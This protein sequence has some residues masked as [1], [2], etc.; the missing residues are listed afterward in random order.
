MGLS[1]FIARLPLKGDGEC[2]KDAE[3]LEAS[4]SVI[5]SR[6]STLPKCLTTFGH[7]TWE[8]AVELKKLA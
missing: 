7:R 8:Q 4:L 2:W 5:G 1:D 3:P 6:S